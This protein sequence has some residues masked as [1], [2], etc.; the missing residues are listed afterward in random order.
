[1]KKDWFKKQRSGTPTTKTELAVP[2]G[3][4]YKYEKPQSKPW[5]KLKEIERIQKMPVFR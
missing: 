1:V 2:P 4:G 3:Y 5:R